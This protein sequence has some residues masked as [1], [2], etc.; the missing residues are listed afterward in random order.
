MQGPAYDKESWFN[1]AEAVVHRAAWW[2]RVRGSTRGAIARFAIDRLGLRNPL[3]LVGTP[4]PDVAALVEASVLGSASGYLRYTRQQV[5]PEPTTSEI[6]WFLSGL[7][8]RG[9]VFFLSTTLSLIHI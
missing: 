2:G 5:Q 7:G 3:T 8:D 6:H 9:A 1:S 4:P